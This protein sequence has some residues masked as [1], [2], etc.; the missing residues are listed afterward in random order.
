MILHY[1]IP[2]PDGRGHTGLAR[3][4]AQLLLLGASQA[5]E[6]LTDE[7]GPPHNAD[8]ILADNRRTWAPSG[9]SRGL[10]QR[11]WLAMLAS[12]LA[13]HRAAQAQPA[14]KLSARA[15]A[16]RILM[17]MR[18]ALQRDWLLVGVELR[19]PDGLCSAWYWATHG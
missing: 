13:T 17:H 11:L 18:A 1:G 7:T 8:L 14:A 4:P 6:V 19:R 5:P 16:A 3:L 10:W 12:P 15:V 9:P 2:A